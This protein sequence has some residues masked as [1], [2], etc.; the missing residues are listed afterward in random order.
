MI[1]ITCRSPQVN[2]ASDKSDRDWSRKI[3]EA[4][5]QE[6]D[7]DERGQNRQRAAA[8]PQSFVSGSIER[9][10]SH[11]KWAKRF[12]IMSLDS[13]IASPPPEVGRSLVRPTLIVFALP[14][15]RRC[16]SSV[17][18]RVTRNTSP[19]LS[20]APRGK[21]GDSASVAA[22]PPIAERR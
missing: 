11:K 1:P 15:P 3:P 9:Y 19:P 14:L 10:S 21:R 13:R 6:T 2:C 16:A 20:H 5:R 4:Q 7:L 12:S 8:T 18:T 22:S 17:P